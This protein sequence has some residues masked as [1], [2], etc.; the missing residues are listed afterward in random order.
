MILSPEKANNQ[1]QC[2][3]SIFS[4]EIPHTI[5]YLFTIFTTAEQS[6][7]IPYIYHERDTNIRYIPGKCQSISM[8]TENRLIR[9]DMHHRKANYMQYLQKIGRSYT[10]MYHRSIISM[11]CLPQSY[12]PQKCQ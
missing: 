10:Y 11:R 7:G 1:I 12:L 8:F 3:N 4:N 9:Q 6:G 5:S 2:I